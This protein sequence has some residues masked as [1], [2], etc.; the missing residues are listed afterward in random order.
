V[1][2]RGAASGR[3]GAALQPVLTHDKPRANERSRLREAPSPAGRHGGSE[4][5]RSDD[6]LVRSHSPRDHADG[7]L[8]CTRRVQRT[9]TTVSGHLHFGNI[10]T[11]LLETLSRI[12]MTP[13]R[14]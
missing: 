13:P 10:A 6:S 8:R 7:A 3:G 12:G 14:P 5:P 4:A 2:A 9:S 11:S 1:H